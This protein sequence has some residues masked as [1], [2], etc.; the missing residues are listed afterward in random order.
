MPEPRKLTTVDHNASGAASLA[1]VRS[2][3][4]EYLNS[5]ANLIPIQTEERR[6]LV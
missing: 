5:V 6:C 4:A 2:G 1:L 3:K